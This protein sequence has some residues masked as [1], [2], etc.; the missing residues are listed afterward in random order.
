MINGLDI[1]YTTKKI[2]ASGLKPVSANN[3]KIT[4]GLKPVSTRGNGCKKILR[5]LKI[6]Q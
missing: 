2:V 1:Y 5:G 6:L 4:S 3:K